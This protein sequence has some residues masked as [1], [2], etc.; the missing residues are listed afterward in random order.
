MSQTK[1]LKAELVAELTNVVPPKK[2]QLFLEAIASKNVALLAQAVDAVLSDG[3]MATAFIEQ[4]LSSMLKHQVLQSK[5]QVLSTLSV[6]SAKAAAVLRQG[7]NVRIQL[8]YVG[9]QAICSV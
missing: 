6:A 2:V 8:L 4:V 7:G 1:T 5:D 3:L 9:M